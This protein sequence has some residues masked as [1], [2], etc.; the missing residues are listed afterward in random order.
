MENCGEFKTTED[1]MMNNIMTIMRRQI[2]LTLG[3]LDKLQPQRTSKV[4]ILC[5][6][7]ISADWRFGVSLPV[8][9]AQLKY[10]HE[11]YHFMKL[12]ELPAILA[13]KQPVKRP[14]V[15][16]TFDDGYA[17]LME[18]DA[19]MKKYAIHPTVFLLSDPAHAN[20]GE[21]GTAKPLLSDA[22][23]RT[24]L[25]HGWEI[26]SHSATHPDFA[27]ITLNTSIEAEVVS[28]KSVLEKKFGVRVNAIAYPKGRYSREILAAAQRAG[29]H[30][31]VT[32]DD[33][34]ITVNTSRFAVPRIGVD[35]THTFAEFQ[36][37]VTDT[38]IR[39][40]G[41]VKQSSFGRL[42]R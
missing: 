5:Y 42:A 32:M 37:L 4:I 38:A 22:Q 10:L 39:W 26:G 18:I 14:T 29:Y 28:S 40:R 31:G 16:L 1:R 41:W 8:F 20:R 11:H 3:L 33:S 21:M 6:H 7:S 13:G 25:K 9:A 17:D 15:F 12:S 27:A 19:L 30:I 23:V 2:Y 34:I 35:G 24:L 36:A